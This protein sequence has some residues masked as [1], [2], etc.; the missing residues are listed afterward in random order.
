[1]RMRLGVV[2][3]T[4]G[5]VFRAR[6]VSGDAVRSARRRLLSQTP[7]RRCI[8]LEVRDLAAGWYNYFKAEEDGG[9]LQALGVRNPAE[10]QADR[11]LRAGLLPVRVAQK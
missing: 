11:G 3:L 4:V 8:G 6:D 9:Q 7:E 10:T 5:G 1:M 2:R